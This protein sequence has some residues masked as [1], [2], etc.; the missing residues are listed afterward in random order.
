MRLD[1]VSDADRGTNNFDLLRLLG[2]VLVVFAHSFDLLGQ[3]EPF[4]ELAGMNWGF[5]GILIFF[6]ISG[7]LVSRS[8]ARNPR[9]VPF[10]V[11]RALR[12]MPALIVALTLTALVLGPF[13]SVLQPRAYFDDPATKTYMVNNTLM[14]TDYEL[15]GVFASNHYPIAV[16]GS[17]WTL[18]LEVKAYVLVVLLGLGG[19]LARRRRLMIGIAILAVLT[20]VDAL[21][22]IL[23]G[24][25]Y[26]V[27]LLRSIPAS[28]ELVE[29]AN[30]GTFNIFA[31]MF[32][33]FAIGAALFSLR[34]WVVLR[35]ELAVL[36]VAIWCGT[37]ALGGSAPA[38][39]AVVVGPYLVLCLAY[40]THAFVRLP[41]RWGDYSYGAYIYAF[42][43]QQTISF[44]LYPIGGWLMFL[45]ATPITFALAIPSWHLI[46]R[47][48][49]EI[50]HRLT[51]AESPAGSPSAIISAVPPVDT[52]VGSLSAQ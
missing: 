45:L 5:V 3:S 40:G 34:R 26:F 4:P 29:Q 37:I 28:P 38:I 12:L 42:P 13:V 36:A 46:E 31:E 7:F 25:N 52:A 50:K 19:L 20:C 21:R 8:W 51:G 30:L 49:L 33:A 22:P 16:N 10:V 44:L 35:W 18:P 9:I 15:P 32:A 14:Q 1:H 2:A 47:P 27:A 39:G 23:P 24:A 11:K 41:S 17:L 6:S 48:A 43:V